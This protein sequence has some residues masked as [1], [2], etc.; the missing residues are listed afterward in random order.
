[1]TPEQF[2]DIYSV[3]N[4]ISWQLVFVCGAIAYICGRGK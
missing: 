3:L 1:M 2:K 4:T